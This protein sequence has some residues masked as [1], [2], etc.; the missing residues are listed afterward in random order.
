MKREFAASVYIF[1]Q[2]RVL[3]VYHQKLKKWLPPG[4]H[5]EEGETPE[6][7]AKREVLEEV[8]LEIEFMLQ[9][10][11]SVS[12]YNAISIP[13]PYMMLLE[14]IPQHKDVEAHQ[15]VDCIFVAKLTDENQ[16]VVP[17][18]DPPRW[19]RREEIEALEDNIAIFLETKQVLSHLFDTIYEGSHIL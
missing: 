9:N 18:K 2:E 11:I 16:K 7:A 15:H 6:E 3:L 1:S 12:Q 10:G 13:S 19:F 14:E 5:L 8:G 4:G 17:S